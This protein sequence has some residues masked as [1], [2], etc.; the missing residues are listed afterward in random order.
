MEQNSPILIRIFKEESVLEVWKQQKATG[1]YALLKTYDI[2][3]WSGDARAEDQG[4]RPPG[5][6]GLLHDHARRR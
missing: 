2:C 6:G 5:A 3:T 1:R 4:G